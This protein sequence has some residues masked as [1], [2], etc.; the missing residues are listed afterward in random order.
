[1]SDVGKSILQ[2]ILDSSR[3]LG[4]PSGFA[5]EWSKSGLQCWW[6]VKQS[7]RRLGCNID[8]KTTSSKWDGSHEISPLRPNKIPLPLTHH[9]ILIKSHSTITKSSKKNIKHQHIDDSVWLPKVVGTFHKAQQGLIFS[10]SPST[11]KAWAAVILRRWK[12]CSLDS[13]FIWKENWQMN[14]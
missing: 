9:K 12:V 13:R 14:K 10:K 11:T 3:F 4:T 5:L 6:I 2:T 1:M 7:W 8:Q